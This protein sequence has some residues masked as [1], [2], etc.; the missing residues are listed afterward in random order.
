MKISGVIARRKTFVQPFRDDESDRHFC[1]IGYDKRHDALH[2]HDCEITRSA[3]SVNVRE[4]D[5]TEDVQH[6]KSDYGR[7]YSDESLFSS[8]AE[9]NRNETVYETLSEKPYNVSARRARYR[10]YAA[11]KTRKHGYADHAEQ[12]IHAGGDGGVLPPENETRKED[13]KRLQRE[14]NARKR[15]GYIRAYGYNRHEKSDFSQFFD[16]H[17]SLAPQLLQNSSF[18]PTSLPQ[19]GHT[20]ASD[21]PHLRQNLLPA[22]FSSPQAHFTVGFS[23]AVFTASAIFLT[24]GAISPAASFITGTLS[25][26]L[27]FIISR[28]YANPSRLPPTPRQGTP[29]NISQKSFGISPSPPIAEEKKFAIPTTVQTNPTAS[30]IK[31]AILSR[32]FNF[33]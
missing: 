30:R 7:E 17:L 16:F 25:F 8:L 18:A 9:T 11:L 6:G 22:G 10:A 12:Y 19:S 4:P 29:I 31:P 28:L 24:A 5:R 15:N 32:F 33:S 2:K 26:L 23:S 13:R 3:V 14:R 1:K 21:L 20:P 27:K